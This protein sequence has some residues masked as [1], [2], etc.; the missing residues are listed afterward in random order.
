M[1]KKNFFLLL[2]F[3]LFAV[4]LAKADF[5]K[6]FAQEKSGFAVSPPSFEINAN[7][8]DVIQNTIKVDNLSP[9]S[10]K[11]KAKPQNFVAYGEGGQVNLTDEESSFS[12]A[13]WVKLIDKEQTIAPKSFALFDFELEIPKNAEPGSHYGAI[14]FYTEADAV[15]KGSGASV[16]QE[17]GSLILIKLPGKVF[18]DAKLISF[19]PLEQVFKEPK[20][21]LIALLEN[22]GNIHV[23]PYGFIN[24]T[25][26]L[27]QKVKTVEVKGR[28]I[29]PGSRRLFDEEFKFN[30]IGYFKADINLL[31]AGGGKLL[32]AETNFVALNLVALKKYLIVGLII[33]VI[34]FIFRNRINRALKVILTG[35]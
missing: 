25:N 11:I 28:N 14:V 27:G 10:L 34:Y 6:V 32:K 9:F 2:F 8:G 21:K 19:K 17:I 4:A 31:Y 29:L 15:V 35:K 20:I 30:K 18:E 16:S 1:S 22:A 24:I 12:I 7:P 3:T 13:N 33:L 26:V 23:K 5:F